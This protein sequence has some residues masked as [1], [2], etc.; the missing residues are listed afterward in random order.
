MD[1]CILFTRA[2][3]LYGEPLMGVRL[4][5]YST[6]RSIKMKPSQIFITKMQYLINVLSEEPL[7]LAGISSDNYLTANNV[8]C[9]R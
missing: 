1:K 3:A 4:S 2:Q 9:E 5:I 6:P 8:L 7:T